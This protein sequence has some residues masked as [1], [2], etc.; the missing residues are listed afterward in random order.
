MMV[1]GCVCI[2]GKALNGSEPILL[3]GN[4]CVVIYTLCVNGDHGDYTEL[5]F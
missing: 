1:T 4:L 3:G 2:N 5:R